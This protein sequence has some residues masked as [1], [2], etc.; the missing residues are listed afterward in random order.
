M[1]H[2]DRDI[3]DIDGTVGP[4]FT[5]LSQSHAEKEGTVFWF[6]F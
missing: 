4:L 3:D 5:A 6:S 1:I 2:R